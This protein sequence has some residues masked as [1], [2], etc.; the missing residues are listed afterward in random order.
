MEPN[1][2][3]L[4]VS[5]NTDEKKMKNR[6]KTERQGEGRLEGIGKDR[7]S[8][9]TDPLQRSA[10]V[11]SYLGWGWD[12]GIRKT[13]RATTLENQRK[14]PNRMARPSPTFP[15]AWP[16]Q[17]RKSGT[18][19]SCILIGGRLVDQD[20]DGGVVVWTTGRSARAK[21]QKK[22]EPRNSIERRNMYP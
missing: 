21:K 7:N 16:A 2:F 4:F 1:Q 18:C 10:V 12:G 13:K 8:D 11:E 5:E 22:K 19:V 6:E 15:G 14:I 20:G 3:T 17:G 9:R